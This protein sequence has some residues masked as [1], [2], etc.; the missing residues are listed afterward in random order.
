MK[1]NEGLLQNFYTTTVR[2][3]NIE[4]N[5]IQMKLISLSPVVST[6]FSRQKKVAPKA[7]ALK[8][9]VYFKNHNDWITEELKSYIEKELPSSTA[10]FKATLRQILPF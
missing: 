7:Y 10:A 8:T 1:A 5:S 3:K 2:L 4:T 9:I 6:P